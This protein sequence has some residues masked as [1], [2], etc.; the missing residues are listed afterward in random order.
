MKNWGYQDDETRLE[1]FEACGGLGLDGA[2]D[3]R[4]AEHHAYGAFDFLSLNTAASG[5][6]GEFRRRN[7]E[8]PDYQLEFLC[9]GT[10]AER[11][12]RARDAAHPREDAH[13]Q[14]RKNCDSHYW[15]QRERPRGAGFLRNILADRSW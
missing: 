13:P 8:P 4:V 3:S 7:G 15:P 14:A 6:T 12:M 9:L 2:G 1:F 5:R 10:A 11:S